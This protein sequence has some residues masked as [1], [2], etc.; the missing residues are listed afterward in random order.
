[1]ISH[2]FI[3]N[4]ILLVVSFIYSVLNMEV[5]LYA[6][7]STSVL[8]SINVFFRGF[9]E[10]RHFVTGRSSLTT[11]YTVA[12][13]I[14]STV[15]LV[16]VTGS[17]NEST[18]GAIYRTYGIKTDVERDAGPR[19]LVLCVQVCLHYARVHTCMCH[20]WVYVCM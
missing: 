17:Y 12:G 18:C 16:T 14:P 19:K 7:C 10:E 20:D 5:P 3:F 11:S 2:L 6:S 4:V 15:Y 8:Q 1:M 9:D 13:L